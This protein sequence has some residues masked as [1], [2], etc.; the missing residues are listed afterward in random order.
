MNNDINLAY[1]ILRIAEEHDTD[2]ANEI[3]R[4]YSEAMHNGN[5]LMRLSYTD[6]LLDIYSEYN[7]I[8]TVTDIAQTLL[9]NSVI[10]RYTLRV[11]ESDIT[12]RLMF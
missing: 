12:F 8:H 7:F 4:M 5:V 3:L 6:Q 9:D 10:T 2:I 11:S 1:A